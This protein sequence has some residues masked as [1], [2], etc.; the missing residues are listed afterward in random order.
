MFEH[1]GRFFPRFFAITAL[2]LAGLAGCGSRTETMVPVE[3]AVKYQG[4]PLPRGSIALHPDAGKGNA[5]KGESR[6]TIE[7]GR[8]TVTT[9]PHTGAPAGWYKV[10]VTATEPGDPKNP[11]AIRKSLIPERFGNVNES[12][13][14]LEV[15]AGAAAGAYDLDLK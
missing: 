4:K 13:L 3:G 6:G 2:L 12:G 8:Y 15:K 1:S 11:Y 9:H 5:G 7:D 10:A 14:T